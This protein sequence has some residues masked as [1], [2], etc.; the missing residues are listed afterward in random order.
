MRGP[1][2]FKRTLV[3][4]RPGVDPLAAALRALQKVP[5]LG[6]WHRIGERDCVR[7][8]L[9]FVA[10]VETVTPQQ[11]RLALKAADG[12]GTSAHDV[13]PRISEAR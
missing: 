13:R 11:A 2:L 12:D 3:Q 4:L 6:H 8:H 5:R 1:D 10:A 7:I 9:A